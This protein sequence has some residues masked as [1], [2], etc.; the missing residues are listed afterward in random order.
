MGDLAP[1]LGGV[2]L[3]G[4]SDLMNYEVIIG[5]VVNDNMRGK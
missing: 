4:L 5:E 1:T 3:S 2:S